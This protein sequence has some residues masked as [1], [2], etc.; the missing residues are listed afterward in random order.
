[1]A[2]KPKAEV[3]YLRVLHKGLEYYANVE[4]SEGR[5]LIMPDDWEI[6]GTVFCDKHFQGTMSFSDEKIFQLIFN[7]K[8][9]TKSPLVLFTRNEDTLTKLESAVSGWFG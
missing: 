9:G 4:I 1:M 7:F 3:F 8:N 2:A 5:I 6:E